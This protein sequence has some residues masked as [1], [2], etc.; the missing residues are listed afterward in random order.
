MDTRKTLEQ[1]LLE[2]FDFEGLTE[3]QSKEL[4][5]NITEMLLENTFTRILEDVEE[6]DAL[7]LESFL[8]KEPAR[9]EFVDY[10]NENIP[11]FYTILFE[12]VEILKN[13]A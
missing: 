12:E 7:K 2:N 13:E 8:E 10:L 4:K 11:E 5:N 6:E 9:D 1:V 3:E